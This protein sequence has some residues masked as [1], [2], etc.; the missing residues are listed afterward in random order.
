MTDDDLFDVYR[1]FVGTMY[2]M[3][4][5]ERWQFEELKEVLWVK[6]G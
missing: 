2:N 5:I 6:W 4:I 3:G 1:G